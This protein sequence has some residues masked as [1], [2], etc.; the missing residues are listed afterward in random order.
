MVS[1]NNLNLVSPAHFQLNRPYKAELKLVF[2]IFFTSA[3]TSVCDIFYISWYGLLQ[4]PCIIISTTV[5][6]DQQ[7][8][9]VF[10]WGYPQKHPTVSIS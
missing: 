7:H 4:I 1:V 9:N 6:L 5:T 10:L 3:G 8:A 2:V